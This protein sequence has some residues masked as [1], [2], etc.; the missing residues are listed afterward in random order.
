MEPGASGQ[1]VVVDVLEH[2]HCR[3]VDAVDRTH[4]QNHV[5]NLAGFFQ[6]AGQSG[7]DGVQVGKKEA[8]IDA[9]EN[10]PWQGVDRMTLDIAEVFAVGNAANDGNVRVAGAVDQ[11]D[12]G[13]ENAQANAGF[14]PQQA[15][16]GGGTQG[17][18]PVGAVVAP[19]LAQAVQV[20]H[21]DGRDDDA[22]SQYGERQ[23]GE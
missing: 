12:Q 9:Q 21:A 5:V 11:G 13:K 2:F 7:F 1:Q 20:D 10:H 6:F 17:G 19:G 14:Q 18:Q 8:F 3:G 4:D 22:G 16:P 15:D 23:T